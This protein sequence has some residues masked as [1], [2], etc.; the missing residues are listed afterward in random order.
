M[1]GG[2]D[3]AGEL[4]ALDELIRAR[5]ADQ[6][7]DGEQVVNWLVIVGTR[8]FRNF[9]DYPAGTAGTVIAIPHMGAM[10]PW[11]AKGL[12]GHYLDLISGML[13]DTDDDGDES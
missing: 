5:V 11:E 13:D 1:N 8:M 12:M 3:V 4:A 10:P 9:P 7:D 6:L 2:G